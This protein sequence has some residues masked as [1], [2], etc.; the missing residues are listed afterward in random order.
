MALV[1]DIS[2]DFTI[3]GNLQGAKEAMKLHTID[4]F[5]WEKFT[6]RHVTEWKCIGEVATPWPAFVFIVRQNIPMNTLTEL[7]DIIIDTN[8]ICQQIKSSPEEF[9][10]LI[11]N[12][13]LLKLTEANE[14]LSAV[15][16]QC[17][18]TVLQSALDMA[19]NAL[20]KCQVLSSTPKL[21]TFCHTYCSITQPSLLPGYN[22]RVVGLRKWL[23]NRG[24]ATD[25]PS[26]SSSSTG[27]YQ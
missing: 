22:W 19:C 27:K 6:C 11:A 7:R 23:E 24:D 10:S 14:W 21:S 8:K 1:G 13:Y 17:D 26:S 20:V 16:W 2:S 12:K 3:V 18:C 25:H 15:S 9:S 4:G 5:M